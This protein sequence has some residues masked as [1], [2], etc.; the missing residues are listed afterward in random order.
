M[1][2]SAVRRLLAGACAVLLSGALAPVLEAQATPTGATPI[3]YY[4]GVVGLNPLG[5]PFD[6]FSIEG[7]GAIAP[8]VTVGGAASYFGPG[9]D[10]D[11]FTSGDVKFRY[12]PGETALDGFSVGLG[13]GVTRR[14]ARVFSDPCDPVLGCVEERREATGPT[15]SV[16]AD[17]YFLLGPRR[18][19]FV[20]TGVGAKRWIV[21]RDTRDEVDA[22]RAWVYARFL[23]GLAF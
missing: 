7:E 19:F 1:T 13:V 18:R 21:D 3:R 22:E 5:I 14:S 6:I 4:R 17:Y 2:P 23:V 8:G 20:G 15:V 9:D 12:Y 11:H 16:I 10:N